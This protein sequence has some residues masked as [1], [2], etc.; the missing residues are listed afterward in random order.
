[1]LTTQGEVHGAL[2]FQ[3]GVVV[4]R[5]APFGL[6]AHGS[7]MVDYAV[8]ILQ[9]EVLQRE[10]VAILPVVAVVEDAFEGELMVGVDDPVEGCGIALPF[11]GHVVL[12]DLVVGQGQLTRMD[13]LVPD[14]LHVVRAAWCVLV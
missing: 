4:L 7:F 13:V 10:S 3:A 12:A 8:A 11:A 1:M 14:K 9:V 5:G 6:N 2:P